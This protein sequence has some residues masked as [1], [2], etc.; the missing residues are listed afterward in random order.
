MLLVTMALGCAS[1]LDGEAEQPGEHVGTSSQAVVVNPAN[2]TASLITSVAQWSTKMALAPDG[3][4]FVSEQA[5]RIFVIKNGAVLATPFLTLP[6]VDGSGE[7]GVYD[8][9]FDPNF[10]Q[11]NYVYVFYTTLTGGSH[12]RIS[13]FTANG[14]VA[15]VGSEL[16][17]FDFPTLVAGNHLGGGMAFGTDGKLYATHGE[18]SQ[19]QPAQQM[20]TTLGKL[21]RINKD[22]TIPTDNPFYAAP[23]DP[24]D[25][26]WALGLRSPFGLAAQRTGGRI[27]Y[28]DV[29]DSTYEEVNDVV[30]GANYGWP[31]REGTTGSDPV[32]VTTR[33]PIYQYSHTASANPYGCA[34][35]GGTFYD[36]VNVTFPA[37]YVGKYFFAEY[38]QG[39]VGLLDPANNSVSMFATGTVNIVDMEVSNLDGALYYLEH[40]GK[41][42]KVSY[43]SAGTPPAISGQ[44]VNTTVSVG[45]NA[46]FSASATG[47]SPLS[48]QWRRNNVNITGA[49]G[50]TYTLN[51]AQLADSG[52]KFRVVVTNAFGTATS[53]EA[54]LTVTSNTAPTPTFTT[55]AVGTTY[56]A[57]S[58][59]A[60][61][62]NATDT[63]DGTLPASA[64]K[65]RI[66]FYHDAHFH[67]AMPD[68]IGTKTG[69]YTTPNTGEHSANVWFRVFLTV[70]DSGGLSTTISRDVQPLKSNITVASNPAGLQITLDDQP[71]TAPQ[72]VQS[73]VGMQ[74]T[75]GALPQTV[76][77]QSYVFSSWSNGGSQSQTI[78]TPATNTTYTA[79][80]TVSTATCDEVAILQ[81]RDG[82]YV[83]L[84]GTT[85]SWLN[86]TTSLAAAARFIR[87]GTAGAF[88]LRSVG[89]GNYV[90]SN[91]GTLQATGTTGAT[92][93]EEAC[94]TNPAVMG[95]LRIDLNGNGN[96]LDDANNYW[97]SNDT[98]G[99]TNTCPAANT[100][101]WEKFDVVVTQ[102]GVACNPPPAC[103]DVALARSSASASSVEGGWAAAQAIDPQISPSRWASA[104]AGLTDAQAD[105]Q[106]LSVD[107]GQNRW[108]GR[109]VLN[110]EAASAKDYVVEL[111]TNGTTWWTAKSFTGGVSGARIDTLTGLATPHAARYVR[112]RGIDRATAWGYSLFDFGIFGDLNPSCGP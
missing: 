16:V 108:V 76:N 26:I 15:V 69:S 32:G 50:A 83:T 110:W 41:V 98:V 42:Y 106:W 45:G 62:G 7:H 97:K 111:S 29:G 88:T 4:I 92:I 21:I 27:F 3:R 66:D 11:N 68:L 37:T 49:T 5:G 65:W 17:L 51:G 104:Y 40:D 43:N 24:T 96:A 90:V 105:A 80:F 71:A 58:A 109:V 33:L 82:R 67:P 36:P 101:A 74:R 14:D 61:S 38:C 47:T 28:N 103:G 60:F 54:T 75:L 99:L 102:A 19:G 31:Y 107:L 81:N 30:R 55:P 46:T 57:G 2:F 95:A 53:N 35:T 100:V 52:A 25:A 93:A 20:S 77:G 59:I 78:T 22:G 10:A 70:T 12:D 73:V 56:T 18:N 39:W 86:G 23:V 89:T 84:A 94:G 44:P 112:M 8:L 1:M 34:V 64:F 79:N 9:I 6:N 63:Q 72:T 87:S 13:R 91:A 48:Y 85:L